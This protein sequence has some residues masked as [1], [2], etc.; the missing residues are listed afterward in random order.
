MLFV[1]E[2]EHA[3]TA[4][5]RLRGGARIARPRTRSSEEVS[6]EV[7]RRPSASSTSRRRRR[8]RSKKSSSEDSVPEIMPTIITF[9]A[10]LEDQALDAFVN[11]CLKGVE[12]Q[13][14]CV[15]IL[16][17]RFREQ[18]S[19]CD[20]DS[21]ISAA[22]GAASL[23]YLGRVTHN[24]EALARGRQRYS[25]ALPRTQAAISDK[26]L[27]ATDKTLLAVMLLGL[28][29]L[30]NGTFDRQTLFT[31]M[32]RHHDGAQALLRHR[33]H[34]PSHTPNIIDKHIRRT[35]IRNAIFRSTG[36]DT[37][38]HDGSHFGEEPGR[39]LDFDIAMIKCVQ[40][41]YASKV[42]KT[43]PNPT[44]A[45][46][47][48]EQSVDAGA[49]FNTWAISA[50]SDIGYDS[51]SVT[52]EYLASLTLDQKGLV[53]GKTIHSYPSLRSAVLWNKYRVGRI[54]A[55][56][57]IARG[58]VQFDSAESTND[59][60]PR[61]L[62]VLS[63]IQALV[64]DICASIPYH[65][66]LTSTDETQRRRIRDV[67]ARRAYLL[68]YPLIIAGS[69]SVTHRNQRRWILSKLLLVSQITGNSVLE[70]VANMDLAGCD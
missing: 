38:L 68:V 9:P 25:E 56:A 7:S 6:R 69:I 21:A 42:F 41:R 65:F 31:D 46:A 23:S 16:L 45:R 53:F 11:G 63:N 58:L 62:E 33:F 51:L 43:D 64:N 20:K 39:E 27:A 61:Y 29:E 44:A 66:G 60:I 50:D 52:P 30:L 15:W 28:Y 47:L 36:L 57:G 67:N 3:S 8:P 10:V 59:G 32:Y 48:V 2:N 70:Q 24:L 12:E 34:H 17:G 18:W 13:P 55:E 40:I 22:L 5:P 1:N 54:I 19:P 14:D 35:L 49:N 37:W 4:V 26:D